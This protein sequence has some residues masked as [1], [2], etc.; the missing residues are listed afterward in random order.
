MFCKINENYGMTHNFS[1]KSWKIGYLN[2]LQLKKGRYYYPSDGTSIGRNKS[3]VLRKFYSEYLERYRLGIGGVTQS[4][5]YISYGYNKFYGF[6][7]T[8]GTATGVMS[9]V[10]I[11]KALRELIEKNEL[12]NFWFTDR[13]LR[14][15]IT[16]SQKENKLINELNFVADNHIIIGIR[17]ISNFFTVIVVSFKNKVLTGCGI[18]CESNLE[19]GIKKALLE[20]K[21]IEWQQYKNPDSEFYN[22]S[23]SL[24]DQV[25]KFITNKKYDDIPSS[26]TE[27]VKRWVKLENNIPKPE[28]VI[29]GKNMDNTVSIKLISEYFLNCIPKKKYL[30]GSSTQLITSG[31]NINTADIDCILV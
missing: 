26:T 25:H 6:I 5:N 22:Q 19:A 21:L 14:F 11:D 8:T 17:S 7:D 30:K 2:G 29:L 12:F 24:G 10:I 27:Q 1:G 13:G 18:A 20:N 15:L 28:I 3:I 4:G 31:F 23:I 16:P 9:K